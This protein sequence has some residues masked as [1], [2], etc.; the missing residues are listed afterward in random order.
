MGAFL[1]ELRYALRLLRR[2]PGFTF[3]VVAVLALGIGSNA[4]IFSALDQIVIRP[5]PYRAPDRLVTLWEDFSAFGQA[6]NRVS[7]ATL[8]EWRARSRTLEQIAAYAGPR[9]MDLSGGG[10]P[11]EAL[12]MSVS[13]NLLPM[14][15]VQPL[16]GRVF[17]SGEEGPEAKV[18][19]LSYRLWQRR[20]GGD[21]A[22]V[23]HPVAMNGESYTILGVMPPAFSFPDRD[24]A[25]WMPLGLSPQLWARRNSHFLKVVARIAGRYS[26]PQV[27]NDAAA[28]AR[29]VAAEYP[30]TNA[31]T[32]IAVVPLKDEVL[33]E[34][35]VALAVLLSAAACVLL[36]ACANVGN[37][38]LARV[39]YR[40]GEMAV[41]L[42]L[43]ASPLRV[44]RQALTENLLLSLAGGALGLLFAIGGIR[45]LQP[46]VPSG[47][48]D[49]RLDFRALAFAGAAAI[50]TALLSG[51][52]P[53]LELAKLRLSGRGVVGESRRTLRGVLVAFEVAAALVLAVGATLLLESIA[54][55]R[56]VDPGFR[57]AN[58]LIAD[59][60]VPYPKYADAGIRRRF[61][62]GVLARVRAIPGVVSAGLTSDLPYTSRGNTMGLTVESAQFRAGFGQDALFRLV[63]AGY[64]ETIGARLAE[65]RFLEE[66][67]TENSRP[68]AVV[69][70]SLA[71][72]Y[73]PGKSALGRQIDAGT[74]DGARLWMTV[75]GVVADIRE[76]GLD[77]ELKPAVYVPF[78]QTT[79]AFFQPSEIAVRT[80]G[81]PAGI[82]KALQRSVWSLDP[83]Q[84]VSHIRTMSDVVAGEMSTR[85]QVLTMLGA[86]AA[87]ALL[88]AA[89]GIYGVLSYAV[90]RRRREIGVRIAV[91]ASPWT[92]ARQIAA[93]AARWTAIGLG[94]GILLA[95]AATRLLATL[96]YG[97]SPLDPRAFAAVTLGLAAI[98]LAA[99]YIPARRAA[100]IDPATALR[101]E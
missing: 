8:L 16:L 48:P 89:L 41:R 69:S 28:V 85:T 88:L 39:M 33:G 23:G 87:L 97:V 83:E 54:T 7:P 70:E 92:A 61:Y 66:S 40:R 93:H 96:L 84:P 49:L 59:I 11:E 20:F 44:M 63:S 24:T 35:R 64:L 18:A 79:I 19:I 32:G 21:A 100:S 36:I 46:M 74:G 55:M 57:A 80:L 94:T 77:F 75:A 25:L 91:G 47:L 50:L 90:S 12:G 3:A 13:A 71:R 56:A 34:T 62:R 67:D 26:L 9:N 4:A 37:L 15:G 58:V 68:V 53:A 22:I 52:A 42:A 29:Q 76:R 72:R 31:R 60:A 99:S 78:T 38:L 2:S 43:G 45:A 5:L 73:W 86:F 65:G 98:A 82:A 95:T 6:K 30:A 10:Q 51:F 1:S 81:D 17:S 27:R 14:L 101:E